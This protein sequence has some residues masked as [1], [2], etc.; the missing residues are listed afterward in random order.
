M[1]PIFLFLFLFLSSPAAFAAENSLQLTSPA[2][3]E[4]GTLPEAQTC[5]GKN[6][7][8][9]LRWTT[10][11][12]GTQSL[13]IVMEDP[14]TSK[15]LKTHWLIYNLAP[16]NTSLPSG[17]PV[18]G[19]LAFGEL[20][21]TNDNEVMGYSGPCPPAG[22]TH[23]YTFRLY[24]LDTVVRLKAGVSRSELL[25]AMEGHILAQAELT[26]TYSRKK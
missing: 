13:G 19:E 9:A 22:Q 18:R 16:A 20:Q 12:Q 3:E 15:G 5:D 25:A 17:I 10:P 7:S 4:G 24:A 26:G 11:P 21:G 6:I 14:A 2:F 1:K 8:P 23:P